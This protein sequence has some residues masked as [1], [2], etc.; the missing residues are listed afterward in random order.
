MHSLTKKV[1]Q[2][3]IKRDS[4]SYIYTEKCLKLDENAIG[5]NLNT[6]HYTYGDLWLYHAMIL[7]NECD[8]TILSATEHILRNLM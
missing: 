6:Y 5:K 4:K 8:E 3:L 1:I 7:L 2:I